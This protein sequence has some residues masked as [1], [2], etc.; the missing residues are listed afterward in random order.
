MTAQDIIPY[1]SSKYGLKVSTEQALDIA[2][3]LCGAKPRSHFSAAKDAKRQEILE[4]TDPSIVVP[5][6]P[7]EEDDDDEEPF[8]FDLVQVMSLLLIPELTK[9]ADQYN[10]TTS[11][12]SKNSQCDSERCDLSSPLSF[13][14]EDT[15][16]KSGKKYHTGVADGAYGIFEI[17]IDA[18]LD[19]FDDDVRKELRSGR[20]LDAGM[21]QQ[22]LEAFGDID[23][24][25]DPKLL[26]QMLVCHLSCSTPSRGGSVSRISKCC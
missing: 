17:A 9:L 5:D 25:N 6:D 19:I 21:L 8:Y 4:L 11:H 20:P 23:S 16:E 7:D 13:R 26:K 10:M 14:P 1:L 12:V 24:A 22:I 2:C 15:S 3:N 18:L